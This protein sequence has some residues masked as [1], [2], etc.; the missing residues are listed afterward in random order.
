LDAQILQF[1][2]VI[3]KRISFHRINGWIVVGLVVFSNI[4]ALMITRRAFGGD[5][6]AQTAFGL[7]ALMTQVAFGMA[8]YNIKRLQIDQHRAWMLRAAFY[9]GVM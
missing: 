7:L 4:G 5:L 3:R 8:I 1:V 6:G 2:P 9:L